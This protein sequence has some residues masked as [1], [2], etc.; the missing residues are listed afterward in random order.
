MDTKICTQCKEELSL[1]DFYFDNQTN[2]Y[3]TKC[4]H[5]KN[6][7]R[8]T[9]NAKSQ[10]SRKLKAVQYKG[11]KCSCCGYN[12]CPASLDFHHVNKNTKTAEIGLLIAR[13]IKWELLKIE[14]DNC[15]LL[16]ANC[17]RELHYTDGY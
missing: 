11:G 17:H 14:L 8:S 2:K 5:C 12:K 7:Q 16:C 4:K 9:N 10:R 3:Y 15:I 6:L 1:S 13:N